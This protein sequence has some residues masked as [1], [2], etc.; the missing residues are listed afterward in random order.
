MGSMKQIKTIVILIMGA[1]IVYA[2]SGG[3]PPGVTGAPGEDPRACTRCHRGT[4]NPDQEGGITLSGVPANYIP[5]QRY[6][7]TV[8]VMHSASDRQRWGFQLTALT[9]NDAQPAGEMIITDPQ[10]TRLLVG[11]PGGNRQYVEHTSRGTGRGMTGG[12]SWPFDWVAPSAD[13]GPIIFYAAGNAANND[14]RNTGDKIYTT[15]VVSGSPLVFQNVAA[16][17]GVIGE[18]RGLAWGDYDADGF[19]DLY[20]VRDGQDLLF[21]NNGDGTF[22]EMAVPLGIVETDSGQDAA[23][24]DYDGDGDLDLFVVNVGQSRLY[25]NDGPAGFTEV[26]AMAELEGEFASHAIAVA[27]YDEDGDLD[28]FLANDGPDVLYC[29]NSDGTFTDIADLLNLADDRPGRAAAWG[30]FDGDGT[31]DL[32]VVHL[33]PDALYRRNPDDPGLGFADV[34]ASAGVADEADGWAVAWADFD[35]DGHLDVF[36][37]NDGPDAL[38]RNR[39]DGTFE[40]VAE[41]VGITGEA[42]SRDAAW[43]DFDGDGNVDL[44]VAHADGPDALYRNT[45]EGRFEEVTTALGIMSATASQAVAWAD[46]DGDGDPD[47]A[48]VTTQGL[49][50]YENPGFRAR[51]DGLARLERSSR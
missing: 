12:M 20:V 45:G 16:M 3:P 37:A 5:G 18:G 27:D 1:T 13:V 4:L 17:A 36:V 25:R 48:I 8:T 21:H 42:M 32:F 46:F 14:G 40:N 6:S 24:F 15:A 43:R 30:D 44:C 49:F 31:L 23:W 35:G 9:G 47:L 34:A 26:T 7:L 33:G 38:Y 19:P 11:G 10:T 50:L 29:N 39:G 22:T 51:M 41:Q 28:V 2:F